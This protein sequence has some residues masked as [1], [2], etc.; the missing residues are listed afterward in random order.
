MPED[1]LRKSWESLLDQFGADSAIQ[2]RDGQHRVNAVLELALHL[3]VDANREQRESFLADVQRAFFGLQD[4]L[5]TESTKNPAEDPVFLLGQ[6]S[7][8]VHLAFSM[9]R[10]TVPTFATEVLV[11]SKVA[12]AI[13]RLVA[14]QGPLGPSEIANRLGKKSQN[15]LSP[16]SNLVDC[17]LLRR[18]DFGARVLY[19]A[20]GLLKEALK[21]PGLQERDVSPASQFQSNSDSD[22]ATFAAVAAAA[23]ANL[24]IKP[25]AREIDCVLKVGDQIISREVL[26]KNAT[27]SLGRYIK[28]FGKIK[29]V[30]VV[31]GSEGKVTRI[32]FGGGN[33]VRTSEVTDAAENLNI[34]C[35]ILKPPASLLDRLHEV[36][37]VEKKQYIGALHGRQPKKNVLART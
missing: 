30:K 26:P 3:S 21:A 24:T 35:T 34:K 33:S 25:K 15:I 22:L 13:G 1:R 27:A 37:R 18:D 12:L 28:T 11:K 6:L 36:G 14:Q 7:A 31:S 23:N 19:S 16:L 8:A 4:R 2:V 10:Q 20:T 9:L 32:T 5:T 17:G 29:G